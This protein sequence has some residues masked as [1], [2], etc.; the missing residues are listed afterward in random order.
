MGTYSR[1]KSYTTLK[2]NDYEKVI[3]TCSDVAEHKFN[4]STDNEGNSCTKE[5][6]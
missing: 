1:K 5:I 3:I 6:S 2:K 4:V